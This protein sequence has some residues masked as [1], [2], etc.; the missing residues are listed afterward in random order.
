MKTNLYAYICIKIRSILMTNSVNKP[1]ISSAYTTVLSSL[2]YVSCLFS[3]GI[4]LRNHYFYTSHSHKD[5][6]SEKTKEPLCI[7]PKI[8]AVIFLLAFTCVY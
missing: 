4:K 6:N 3:L 2:L 8:A 1:W 7:M 5:T